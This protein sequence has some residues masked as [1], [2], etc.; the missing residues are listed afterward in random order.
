METMRNT[1]IDIII[2]T[3][4][5][6]DQLVQCIQSIEATKLSRP[7]D[8]IVVN[9]G[10][11]N[12]FQLQERYKFKLLMPDRNLGWTGGLAYGLKSSKSEFVMF[13]NDDIFVP[14]SSTMWLHNMARVLQQYPGVGAVGPASNCV[15]GLQNIW[16][17]SREYYHNVQFLVGFCML[18]RKEALDKIGGLDESFN[19]GDDIDLS[20]RLRSEGYSLINTRNTFVYHHGFQTGE[21]LYGKPDEPGGWN[22]LQMTEQTNDHLIQKHGFKKWWR[23]MVRPEEIREQTEHVDAE[24]DLIRSFVKAG[25]VVELGCGGVRTVEGST[26]VDRV[27]KGEDIPFVTQSS[28]ADIECD[29][30]NSFPLLEDAYDTVIARHIIEHCTDPIHFVLE[31]KRILRKKG[32]LIIAV[33]DE[34]MVNGVEIN[35]EHIHV[36][37]KDSLKNL[38]EVCGFKPIEYAQGYNIMGLLVVFER[39]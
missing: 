32:K 9:N 31:C 21:V 33:P 25:D 24:G 11:V 17:Q 13:A 38:G 6:P 19:T 1:P 5:N 37:T 26:V 39:D 23:T 8:I 28:I 14:I 16:S 27:A 3:Y 10:P 18:V 34:D 7:C 20:I 15:M 29:L 22:S 2:P 35:P 36:F 30:N 4:E 12:L